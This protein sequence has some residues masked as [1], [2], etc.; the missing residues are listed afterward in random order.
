MSCERSVVSDVDVHLN[1][2]SEVIIRVVRSSFLSRKSGLLVLR[3]GFGNTNHIVTI[4]SPFFFTESV[5]TASCR[6]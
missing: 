1:N 3:T 2:L 5:Q 4:N 6:K